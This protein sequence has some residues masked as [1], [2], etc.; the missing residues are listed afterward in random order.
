[1]PNKPMVLTATNKPDEYP[2]TSW[3]QHIGRSLGSQKSN[4]AG[5]PISERRGSKS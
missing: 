3:R 4:N 2:M 5:A 1:M